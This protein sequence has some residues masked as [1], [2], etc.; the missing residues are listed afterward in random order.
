[1]GAA[2]LTAVLAAMHCGGPAE[3]GG[4]G[5]ECFRA[6]ECAAGLVCI[7][8]TCTSNLTRINFRVE[9]GVGPEGGTG[10]AD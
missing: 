9:A 7:E 2:T 8:K 3:A 1:V 4:E 5:A 6:E 10:P